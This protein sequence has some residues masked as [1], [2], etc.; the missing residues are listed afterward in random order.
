MSGDAPFD[1]PDR[2]ERRLDDGSVEYAGKVVY[3]LEPGSEGP[4]ERWV[5]EV[6]AA[7][8]YTAGDWFDLPLPVYL[9]C[10]HEVGSLFRV[11][12]SSGHV[13]LQLLPETDER[14]LSAFFDRLRA[15]SDEIEWS[16]RCEVD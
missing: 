2:P 8:R 16:V 9:V 15:E 13:E 7:D 4:V 12:V 3:R 11:V 1:V 6:L 5:T 14:A 10:D